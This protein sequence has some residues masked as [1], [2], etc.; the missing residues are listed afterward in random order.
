M[1]PWKNEI[2]IPKKYILKTT[3]SAVFIFWRALHENIPKATCQEISEK[4]FKKIKMAKMVF[5]DNGCKVAAQVFYM[6]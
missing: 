5:T 6:F 4:G 3:E 2:H 1:T